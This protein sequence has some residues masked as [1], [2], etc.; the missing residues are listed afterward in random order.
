VN[1]GWKD[2][3]DSIFHADGALAE[4]P[5]ALCEVQAYAYAARRHAAC[6]ARRL[7]Q[8]PLAVR[9]DAAAE[10]LRRRFEQAFWCEELGTYALALDGAKRPC[11]VVASNA[12]HALYCG[13][14]SPERARRVAATL[15]APSSFSGW[16]VRT[17]A[18]TGHR[19]NPM[20]YHDGSVW[21]HDN[22]LIALG[23]ARYGLKAPILRIFQGL[24]DASAYID[25][26]RLP[27]L[28]C[29]FR[30][31]PRKGPTA[32]TVAC[33]PQAWAA[34]TPLALLQASLG[35]VLDHEAGEIRLEYPALPEFVGEIVLRNLRLGD[36]T[37]DIELR[38]SSGE[39]VVVVLRRSGTVRVLATH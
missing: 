9:L 7:G 13:I 24:I 37:A 38:R 22:G 19:Y 34:A 10:R 20:S 1:Q 31:E 3:N 6:L 21:P 28:F 4:G 14:A 11:R 39:V 15:L 8:E 25:L 12:G 33:S 26:R 27:E 23:F 17:V 2:S 32:Y 30:R 5:I 16:G 18:T 36:A 29:G 35:L